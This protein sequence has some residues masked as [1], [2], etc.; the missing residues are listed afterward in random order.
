MTAEQRQ[1]HRERTREYARV[2]RN[3]NKELVCTYYKKYD[4]KRRSDPSFRAS[5]NISRQIRKALCGEKLYSWEKIVGY[6]Q[7]DLRKHLES[8]F[9][10]YMSWDNYGAYWHID[11]IQPQ[12]DFSLNDIEQLKACWALANLRPLE[13]KY[14]IR[15]SNSLEVSLNNFIKFA[16]FE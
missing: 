10:V 5:S 1:I 3:V 2:Y 6:S 14:N 11:H 12:S 15:K 4:K 7:Q 8:Q 16:S 13:A 9:D